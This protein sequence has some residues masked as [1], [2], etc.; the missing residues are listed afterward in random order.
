[1]T[2]TKQCTRCGEVKP[3]SEFDRLRRS[4]DGRRFRCKQ[5][6]SVTG[7]EYRRE[8]HDEI[9]ARKAVYRE[10][11]RDEL[12]EKQKAYYEQHKDERSEYY[13]RWRAL[14]RDSLRVSK[15]AYYAEHSAEAVARAAA[16]KKTP[17][18]REAAIADAHRR[19]VAGGH[20]TVATI[21]D[22]KKEYGGICPYCNQHIEAG[23]I[24][25]I[26]PVSGGG[27]NDRENLVYSCAPC[28]MSKNDMSLLGFMLFRKQIESRE[29]IKRG[30]W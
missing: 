8:H 17:K 18:G 13:A 24:D 29:P 5:C 3:L 23:H 9:L 27:T 14:N 22:V 10:A 15:A 6:R 30:I 20:L 25:H 12:L 19:R 1:M 16:W 21:R 28:N 4:K 2:Q 11:H 7:A 26:V